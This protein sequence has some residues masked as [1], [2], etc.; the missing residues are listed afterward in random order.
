MSKGTRGL[1]AT[2]VLGWGLLALYFGWGVFE[3][4][5]VGYSPLSDFIVPGIALV[6]F[7][8]SIGAPTIL[9]R[10]GR[11]RS[12][13][14]VAVFFVVALLAAIILSILTIPR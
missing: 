8:V 12:A 6:A 5:Q 9:S 14:T 13:F 3:L 10:S 2:A 11:T 1:I 4:Y 7:A